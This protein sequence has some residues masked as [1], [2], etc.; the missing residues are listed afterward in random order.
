MKT[1]SCLKETIYNGTANTSMEWNNGKKKTEL[2]NLN[3][4]TLDA[5]NNQKFKWFVAK[6]NLAGYTTILISKC[7]L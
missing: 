3:K 5:P 4:Y 1:N 7:L 6:T 2:Q